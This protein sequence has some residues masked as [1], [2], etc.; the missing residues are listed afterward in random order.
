MSDTEGAQPELPLERVHPSTSRLIVVDVQNDF[1][2]DGGWFAKHKGHDLEGMRRAVDNAD[3]LIGRARAAGVQPIFMQA[4][5]D[6][7][8]LSKPMLE[9]FLKPCVAG[10]PAVM[11]VSARNASMSA[12]VKPVP[13]TPKAAVPPEF[14]IRLEAVHEA[15]VLL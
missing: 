14:T 4:I 13:P 15:G 7:K 3:R 1:L 8:W 12:A 9:P 2:A 5:Y 6:E 11:F 10:T